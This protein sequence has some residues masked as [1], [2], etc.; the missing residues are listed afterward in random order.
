MLQI[1]LKLDGFFLRNIKVYSIAEI[2]RYFQEIRQK[3]YMKKPTTKNKQD[4]NYLCYRH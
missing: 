2:Q 4:T 3:I 1:I